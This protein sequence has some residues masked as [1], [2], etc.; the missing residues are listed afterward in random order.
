VRGTVVTGILC[1]TVASRAPK[2]RVRVLTPLTVRSLGAVT[3]GRGAG[4]LTSSN[5]C[6]AAN[7]LSTAPLPQALT[8]AM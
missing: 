4:P 2:R 5:R 7:P 6:A 8:A 3:S 1:Q